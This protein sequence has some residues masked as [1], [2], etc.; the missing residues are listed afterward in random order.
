MLQRD[1]F[2]NKGRGWVIDHVKSGKKQRL[3]KMVLVLFILGSAINIWG[4]D[5]EANH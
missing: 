3:C 1:K 5:N 4:M 2:H